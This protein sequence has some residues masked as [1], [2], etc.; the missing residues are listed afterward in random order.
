MKS[1]PWIPRWLDNTWSSPRDRH[2]HQ[3]VSGRPA[4]GFS[5]LDIVPDSSDWVVAHFF[6]CTVPAN[7]NR[8]F[9]VVHLNALALLCL[10]EILRVRHEVVGALSALEVDYSQEEFVVCRSELLS[11]VFLAEGPRH[12]PAQQ[13][14]HRL[15]LCHIRA[16]NVDGAVGLPTLKLPTEPLHNCTRTFGDILLRS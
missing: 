16:L 10:R 14:L 7:K 13:G 2:R 11:E 15:D 3:L 9:Q 5:P 8:R 12:T 4:P 6:R 1:R